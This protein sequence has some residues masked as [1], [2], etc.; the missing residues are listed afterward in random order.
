MAKQKGRTRRW[1]N[2]S[3]FSAI[4]LR[5]IRLSYYLWH[6]SHITAP[7][8]QRREEHHSMPT[9][10]TNPRHTGKQFPQQMVVTESTRRR[11]RESKNSA[12]CTTNCAK[13]SPKAMK[14]WLSKPTRRGLRDQSSRGGIRFTSSKRIC[15]RY[16]QA[17]SLTRF[18]S[19][20]SKSR[21][22]SRRSTTNY[23]FLGT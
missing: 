5:T 17:R 14:E 8:H 23:D 18:E 21:N 10:D 6:S 15:Q 4:T 20:H 16:D 22:G 7:S 13:E 9:I 2:T 19:A 1:N 3:G 12:H 11:L